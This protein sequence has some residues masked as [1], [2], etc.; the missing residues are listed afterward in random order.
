MRIALAIVSYFAGGGLQR[1]CVQVARR[2][3]AKGNEVTI[4][5][6]RSDGTHPMDIKMELLPN[7]ALTNHG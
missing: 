1:D 5:T 6:S 3:I 4:F 7:R 2:L